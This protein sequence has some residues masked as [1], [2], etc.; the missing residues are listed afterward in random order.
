MSITFSSCFYILKSKFDETTYIN[1]MNNFISIVNEFYLVIYTDEKSVKYIDTKNNPRIKIIIKNVDQ[2]YT[3]KYK[4]LWIKNH[5]K[6][7]LLNSRVEWEV[8]MLWN[9][10]IWF[11]NETCKNKYFDTDYYGWCDIGYFRNR[12]NDIN[13]SNLMKWGNNSKIGKIN[14]NTVLYGLV[15][16]NLQYVNSLQNTINNKNT[17]GLPTI[18]ILEDQYSIAG[19][20]FISHKDKIE[21]WVETYYKKLDLYLTNN[22]LVKDDQIIIADCIFSQSSDFCLLQENNPYDNWFMFQRFLQ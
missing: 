4:E 13:T 14:K 22:Y 1:W 6:N 9:E 11:T 5:A 8:N 17:I 20:F 18:P 12:G 15:N 2:F 16:R 19:G 21:W 7:N 10:K 3:Y